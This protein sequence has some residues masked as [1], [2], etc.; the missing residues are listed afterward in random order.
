[1]ILRPILPGI[2]DH[3]QLA[4]LTD[5]EDH[6][7]ALKIDSPRGLTGKKVYVTPNAYY[8]ESGGR[9]RF[10]VNDVEENTWPSQ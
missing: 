1:M 9:T 10:F 6:A 2:T 8:I 3:G 7:W 5:D 4:G